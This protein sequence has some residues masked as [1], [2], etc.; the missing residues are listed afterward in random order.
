MAKRNRNFPANDPKVV[1]IRREFVEWVK[2]QKQNSTYSYETLE[3]CAAGLF[4][5]SKN[6]F[7]NRA[8]PDTVMPDEMLDIFNALHLFCR[9]HALTHPKVIRM[10][11]LP[12]R[13]DMKYT[14]RRFG[15]LLPLL[16]EDWI[17]SEHNYTLPPDSA[18]A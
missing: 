10:V 11:K 4:S 2:R 1:A 8:A 9:A 6:I 18:A 15:D 3:F 5:K 12:G 16:T 14:S 17:S 13:G 7:L